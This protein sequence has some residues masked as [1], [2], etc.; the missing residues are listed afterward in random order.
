MTS[1]P[2]TRARRVLAALHR[3]GW[4]L[5]RQ[6]G[7]HR[8]LCRPGWP[9]YVFAF[10]DREE[11]G[12]RS[13]VNFSRISPYAWAA[14][15]GPRCSVRVALLP[16]PPSAQPRC[17]PSP[18]PAGRPASAPPAGP[19]WSPAWGAPRLTLQVPE[20]AQER[21]K[22]LE[23]HRGPLPFTPLAYGRHVDPPSFRDGHRG[24]QA[25]TV[26]PVVERR[27][28]IPTRIRRREREDRDP[29]DPVGDRL[30]TEVGNDAERPGGKLD[31]E[32]GRRMPIVAAL[33]LEANRLH[34]AIEAAPADRRLQDE[35]QV[36]RLVCASAVEA[37]TGTTRENRLDPGS[38]HGRRHAARHGAEAR[39]SGQPHCG[40]PV[41]LGRRRSAATRPASSVSGSASRCR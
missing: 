1:W 23:G 19:T 13:G 15:G 34:D 9:D 10:H 11:I 36:R 8:T 30:D 33:A 27:Q 12:P 41:R 24:H 5:K 28:A 18:P 25:L 32:G 16:A 7:S 6:T 31:E 2:S 39:A 3:I 4:V 26:V 37:G 17:F 20:T 14:V 29:P 35:I 21:T 22:P 38:R 40:L